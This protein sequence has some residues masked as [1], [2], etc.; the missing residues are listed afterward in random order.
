MDGGMPN[1]L[2]TRPPAPSGPR[3]FSSAWNR[4]PNPPMG[5]RPL[6][7][8]PKWLPDERTLAG[9]LVLVLALAVS[10][11]AGSSTITRP[12]EDA[13]GSAPA[14]AE[15]R[16]AAPTAPAAAAA[17]PGATVTATATAT[18][19]AVPTQPAVVP[20]PTYAPAPIIGSPIAAY[21]SRQNSGALLPTYRILTY[22][23]HPLD[24]NMGI[25]GEYAKA[26]LLQILREEADNYEAVDPSRPVIPAFE[27]IA[28]VAQRDPGADGTYI[29]DTSESEIQEWIDFATENDVLI[30]LDVQI[31]RGT[32][33]A[34]IEKVRPF[35]EQPNVHLALD[36]EFAV[37]EGE[38]PGIYIGEITAEQ[39]TYA[40]QTLAQ[41]AIEQGI[42]PKVLIVHQFREDMIVGKDQVQPVPGV[43]FVLDA[44]GFGAPELKTEVYNILVR[45]E[46][47][48]PEFAGIKLFYKQD[49]PLMTPADVLALSPSPDV[50]IY[51]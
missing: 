29:L 24:E 44:D 36:P 23:G 28:T 49:D 16:S 27:I 20:T 30:V 2:T 32:V 22:Y 6:L 48:Q 25:L 50:I 40:Q 42:P 19:I 51:Q 26:D 8:L 47:P 12:R 31:G 15:A 45:D 46:Q 33:A 13:T 38:T 17:Q 43:Q 1:R 10:L 7:V 14:I 5:P 39:I 34:E 3:P 21:S 41:L 4:S 18:A 11:A 37:A 9:V 35:L